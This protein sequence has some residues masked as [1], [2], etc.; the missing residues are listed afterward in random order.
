MAEEPY[1]ICTNCGERLGQATATDGSDIQPMPGDPTICF[2]CSH[3]MMFDDK[4]E[5]RDPT[6]AETK[7][8]SNHPEIVAAIEATAHV[9]QRMRERF[10]NDGWW[11][12]EGKGKQ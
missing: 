10:G 8:L 3:L 2:V 12:Y 9:R 1:R 4:L 7:E 5:L 6:E 11:A